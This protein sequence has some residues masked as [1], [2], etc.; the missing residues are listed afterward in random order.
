MRNLIKEHIHAGEYAAAAAKFLQSCPTL[1][2]PIDGSPPGSQVSIYV[3]KR[4]CVGGL[5]ARCPE[6]NHQARLVERKVCFI[7]HAGNWWGILDIYPKADSPNPLATSGARAFFRK[8][9]GATR[10]N[11]TVNSDSHLQ[12]GHWR[13]DQH[14]GCFR[15]S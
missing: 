6:A 15:Y 1:C 5:T 3:T 12:I 13:S 10:R 8:K 2:D 4:V 14:L 9:E 11:S 7:S